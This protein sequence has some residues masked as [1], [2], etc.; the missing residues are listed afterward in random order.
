MGNI[1]IKFPSAKVMARIR[2]VETLPELIVTPPD[3][4]DRRPKQG[5]K[6]GPRLKVVKG[7]L[8]PPQRRSRAGKEIRNKERRPANTE[9]PEKG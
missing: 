6:G 5:E 8:A 7:L 2:Y 1:G 3:D 9:T 4:G